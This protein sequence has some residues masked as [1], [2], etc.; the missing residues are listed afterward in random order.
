[1]RVTYKRK[2]EYYS[3]KLYLTE[4]EF[5]KAMSKSPG[6]KLT[7]VRDEIDKERTKAN[8]IIAEIPHFNFDEFRRRF[9]S[10]SGKIDFFERM[11][12]EIESLRKDG[13]EKYAIGFETSLNSLKTFSGRESLLAEEIDV[14]FLK[15]YEKW[16]LLKGRSRTTIGIY[17]RNVRTV[18]NQE[19]EAKNISQSLY[20]FGKSKTKFKIPS[21][22]GTK[23]FLE[24]EELK[25]LYQYNII[26]KSSAHKFRDY[27][28]FIYLCNGLN[29]KDMAMLRY[30]NLT[31]DKILFVREKTKNTTKEKEIR[32]EVPLIPEVSKIIETW[33]NEIANPD[34]FLF[35]ILNEGLS[36]RQ[37]VR[38][39]EDT[40]SHI[41]KTMQQ[42]AEKSGIEKNVTTYVARHSFATMLKRE[43]F[44][45]E[46]I[47]EALGH[48]DVRTTRSYLG[49]F[50]SDIKQKA[51]NSLLSFNNSNI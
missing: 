39:V 17:L 11:K 43:G 22:S 46:F 3:L 44:S 27:W 34:T 4:D 10:E 30:K 7:N 21:G 9:R 26:P 36:P 51:A 1:L 15:N 19:I 18:F 13:R 12:I 38:R 5:E 29:V 40:V 24:K 14:D 50:G 42:I 37:I 48:T 23:K 32:I 16:M 45:T 33:G 28:F 6:K 2:S 8:N 25:K 41:N 49:S 35:P 47:Q 20:P 31:D